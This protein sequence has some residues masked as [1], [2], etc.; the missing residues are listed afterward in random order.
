MKLTTETGPK[1]N[2]TSSVLNEIQTNKVK[3][4]ERYLSHNL[5]MFKVFLRA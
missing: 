1:I 3:K 5:K 4:Q 2:K